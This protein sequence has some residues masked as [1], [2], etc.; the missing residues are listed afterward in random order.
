MP[1]SETLLSTGGA[2]HDGIRL[3]V[4]MYYRLKLRK[5][6][7]QIA[8]SVAETLW[9]DVM[10]RKPKCSKSELREYVGIR[11][12][13]LVYPN[14]D[15]LLERHPTLN[16]DLGNQLQAVATQAVEALV[17]RKLDALSAVAQSRPAA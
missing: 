17:Q 13:Q 10:R 2:M 11:A 12:A 16:G 1:L 4:S 3:P 8:G 7:R 5:Q 9:P 15:A 14:V 6:L